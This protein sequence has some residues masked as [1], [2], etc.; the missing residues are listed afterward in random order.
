[1]RLNLTAFCLL[2]CLGIA[3]AQAPE[4]AP[5][6]KLRF[7]RPRPNLKDVN[8]P[9][10]EEAGLPI[11]LRRFP[12][13]KPA[14]Q[15]DT[16]A[17]LATA[18]DEDST[19]SNLRAAVQE[20][21]SLQNADAL[22]A[23]LST[24]AQ[25]PEQLPQEEEE[26]TPQPA[27][28]RVVPARPAAPI[29]ADAATGA[30]RRLPPN[31]PRRGPSDARVEAVDDSAAEKGQRIP[32][33]PREEP[34]KTTDNY[35]HT[36]P[37]GSFTFG[38]VAEDGSFREETRG[39]D[40]ITRGKYGYIDPEGRKREFTYVSGLP[41]TE[42]A[43][44]DG[45]P[46]TNGLD[47]NE[48]EIQDPISPDERFRSAQPVQLADSD[49]PDS[50]RPRPQ[51]PRIQEEDSQAAVQDQ[52]R[53]RDRPA[54]AVRTGGSPALQN[55]FSVAGDEQP[56]V[57]AP[58]RRPV[59]QAAPA[60]PKPASASFDF[61][62]EVDSFTLNKKPALTFA[63]AAPEAP[64]SAEQPKPVGPNFSSE[65]VFDPASGTF[66]TELRQSVAGE[67]EIRISQDKAPFAQP[68]QAPKTFSP[69]PVPTS[70]ASPTPFTAFASQRPAAVASTAAPTATAAP[71]HLLL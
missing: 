6:K 57:L 40:C 68:T 10:G 53:L 3:L 14:Q 45:I 46:V 35:S 24:A 60:T 66:K 2:V 11:P 54:N 8:N 48:V 27:I 33:R 37:D 56:A 47:N 34:V 52:T 51:R 26:V 22:Q 23:L 7:R 15:A 32:S 21:Q 29:E 5:T 16:A 58:T 28:V 31:V 12:G 17:L 71:V 18:L 44:D 1:M 69:T 65:L 30:R 61:D 49:I 63:T 41:C 42:G 38:Y 50:A 43:G 39:T 36:N 64:K 62:S 55:L 25:E 59:V 67:Q 70:A 4:G 13:G 19:E 20:G 9:E